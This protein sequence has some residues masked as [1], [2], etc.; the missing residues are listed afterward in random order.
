MATNLV[1]FEMSGSPGVAARWG[2]VS[3]AGVSPLGGNFR[4]RQD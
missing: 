3:E 1:R 4:R 2:V